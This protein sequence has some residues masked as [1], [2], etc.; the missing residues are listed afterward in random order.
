MRSACN[1]LRQAA[2]WVGFFQA[3][4]AK[5]QRRHALDILCKATKECTLSTSVIRVG[6]ICSKLGYAQKIGIKDSNFNR[7]I[8]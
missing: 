8:Y 2:Q 5:S 6:S 3:F 4:L 7:K 1:T